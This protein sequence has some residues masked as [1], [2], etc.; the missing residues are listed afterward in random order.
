MSTSVS[1]KNQIPTFLRQV[2]K[3]RGAFWPKKEKLC[4]R[5]HAVVL[6]LPGQFTSLKSASQ[7]KEVNG[8]VVTM[9]NSKC[10]CPAVECVVLSSVM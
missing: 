3:I 5:A 1:C 4:F 8:I 6:W 7:T 9:R 2:L 10:R